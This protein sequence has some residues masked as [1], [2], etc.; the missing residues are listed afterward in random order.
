MKYFNTYYDVYF[1]RHGVALMLTFTLDTMTLNINT[2]EQTVTNVDT[3]G[4]VTHTPYSIF[5][6]KKTKTP[7]KHTDAV[8]VAVTPKPSYTDFV[9]LLIEE[10]PDIQSVVERLD[11]DTSPLNVT[12]VFRRVMHQ[13]IAVKGHVQSGKTKFMLCVSILMLWF[14]VSPVLV[15]RN[16]YSDATQLLQ[17]L[18]DMRGRYHAFLPTIKVIK[19]STKTDTKRTKAAVYVCLGNGAAMKKFNKVIP[20]HYVCLLDEV[21]AMDMGRD[22][23]R[24]AQI[25]VL[26]QNAL[27]VFGVSATMLDPLAKERISSDNVILL[28]T[29]SDYKGIKDISFVPI[30][31]DSVFS[32]RVE[33]DLTEK[34]PGLMDFLRTFSHRVPIVEKGVSYPHIVLVNVGS[35]VSPYMTL[36][37]TL[38]EDIPKLCTIL[39]N[40]N[41]I[42]V[43]SDGK[44]YRRHDSISETLQWLKDEFGAEKCPVIAIFSCV[45]AGRGVS[46]VSE[47]YEWHLN[48]MYLCVSPTCD[49]AELLQ[50]VRLSGR[51]KDTI[52][53]EL[54]TLSTTYADILKAYYKQEEILL[55][56]TDTS[57]VPG[58]DTKHVVDLAEAMSDLTLAKEKFSKR[59]VLKDGVFPVKKGRASKDEWSTAVYTG[60]EFAPK[61]LYE[62]YGEKAPDT[63]DTCRLGERLIVEIEDD[64][65]P[66]GNELDEM[67]RLERKM[68]PSWA[69]RM[70]STKVS[71]WLDD[72]EPEREY[73]R[74]EIMELC[75]THS[76]PLQHVVKA[77]FEMSNSRGYGKI[78]Y[79]D[80]GMYRLQPYLVDAH[81]KYFS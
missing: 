69:K 59:R 42:T 47:D 43:Y 78:L 33:D 54:Y 34:Q 1:I 60:T 80:K 22:T 79:V 10:C 74:E 2:Y 30:T 50:K 72:L 9:S 44:M 21:D 4:I 75:N 3:H 12:H 63:N 65:A 57:S 26:K 8:A 19:S 36:Q 53:L 24:N 55:R 29:A 48:A 73:S 27:M 20:T 23:A 77:K 64:D 49:E 71:A 68:F 39:Y 32:N 62:A 41:G 40:A 76:I 38:R 5:G 6:K 67:K 25:T 46:F 45:L 37:N 81:K 16:L 51:Y 52:P 58:E 11:V 28:K 66:I 18:D 17:R 61:E 14:N 13:Y 15:L 35:T 70:G 31:G 7:T 56:L